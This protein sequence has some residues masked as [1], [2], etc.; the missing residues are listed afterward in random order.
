MVLLSYVDKSRSTSLVLVGATL[1][2]LLLNIPMISGALQIVSTF[3]FAPNSI[4]LLR[5]NMNDKGIRAYT[6]YINGLISVA[7]G[8]R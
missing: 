6:Q 5:R 4:A 8:T 7:F 2:D 3:D 1:L